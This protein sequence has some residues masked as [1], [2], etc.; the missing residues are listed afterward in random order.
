MSYFR[1]TDRIDAVVF[2]AA[3]AFLG[4]FGVRGLLLFVRG[5]RSAPADPLA[6]SIGIGSAVVLV[7]LTWRLWRRVGVN[8]QLLPTA[9][10]LLGSIVC[11]AGMVWMMSLNRYLYGSLFAEPEPVLLAGT[12]GVVGLLLWWR[13]ITNRPND[14]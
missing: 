9:L 10:L 7:Y 5:S 6:F 1:R 8:D 13:R 11:L 3:A 2:L 4:F 14:R 12:V